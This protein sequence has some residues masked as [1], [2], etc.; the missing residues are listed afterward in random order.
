MSSRSTARP[1]AHRLLA[2][3]ALTAVLL[4]GCGGDGDDGASST[5]TTEADTETTASTAAPGGAA[6]DTAPDE[7]ETTQPAEPPA[8][9]PGTTPPD[10]GTEPC[11]GGEHG[12]Q[13]QA[14]NRIVDDVDGDGEYE[15]GWMQVVEG[16]AVVQFGIQLST[17]ATIG[18][19][20]ETATP[21]PYSALVVDADGQGPVEVIFATTRDARLYVL[22]GCEIA[23]V[24]N[25]EGE[26]Y[27]F[28][29]GILGTGTGV[30]CTDGQLVGLN[31]VDDDGTTVTW[32]STAIELDG[33]TARNGDTTEGTFTRP[34]DE[35]RI[36]LLGTIACGT[37]TIDSDGFG[38]EGA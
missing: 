34:Q 16:S 5:T 3:V 2:G 14:V 25:P 29:R 32:T 8:S 7:G 31:T 28:D 6:E 36:A 15:R 19:E 38:Y 13:P 37:K 20:L 10:D 18:T 17:G 30:G 24:T 1:C 9:E 22:D 26:P 35:D 21:P 4:T 23:P 27:T 33:R 12:P 11:P